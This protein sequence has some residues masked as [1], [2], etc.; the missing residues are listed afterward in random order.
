MFG[1]RFRQLGEGSRVFPFFCNFVGFYLYTIMKTTI[2]E[3]PSPMFSEFTMC[4]DL[5][6][7]ML[8][9]TKTVRVSM[10]YETKTRINTSVQVGAGRVG[11]NFKV[12]GVK[13]FESVEHSYFTSEANVMNYFVKSK[14]QNAEAYKEYVK[15]VVVDV[16][17][18][19]LKVELDEVVIELEMDNFNR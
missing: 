10:S 17:T 14:K 9:K 1:Y 13:T 6:K 11:I 7:E 16:I 19:Y 8:K 3:V 2:K 15:A 12:D 5:D 4:A 18:N